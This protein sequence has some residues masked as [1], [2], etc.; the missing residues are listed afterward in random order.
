MH[1]NGLFIF[2]RDYRIVDNNGL[3]LINSKCKNVYTVFI[4]TPEQV[5]SGNHYKSN[6]AVQFMIESLGDLA[7]EIHK[8]G[9]KLHFFYGTNNKVVS[10]CIEAF[11]I[12]YVCFNA[13]YTPYALERD[14]DIVDLCKKKKIECEL[15]QD[16]YL[17]EPG[18]IFSGGGTPYKKFTPYYHAALKKHV[19]PPTKAHKIKFSQSSK[20]LSNTISL[21]TALSKFT[22]A[23]ENILVHGG[24]PDAINTLKTALKNQKH[25]AITHDEVGKPTSLLSAYIKFGCVSVREV[26]KAFKSNH[27]LIRQLI[28][29]DFYMN[30]LYAY[31]YVLGKPMKPAYSKIRWHKNARW[32]DA[33]TKGQTGF[34]IVDAGMRQMNTTGFMHNRAR[35]I[36]AS[37]LTKTL[38][39][40]WR[41]GEEYFATKLTDYDPASNNGNWQFCSSS[42][43]DSQP[44]FRIF[45]P[46]SQSIE[47]DPDCDYIKKWIPELKDVPPKHIQ[48]CNTVW[49]NYK[50]E[51]KYPKPICNYEEQKEKALAMFRAIY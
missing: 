11:D 25:Y 47:V 37:F 16:Y 27:A 23:N 19:Q 1:E 9:G 44:Y 42:G 41:E 50:K 5:G 39:I 48:K 4:F 49:K 34:P 21:V 24:R 33:W 8:Q 30:I 26:Y 40:D 2:R 32:F 7:S 45:N 6:N 15:A 35:L 43:A 22:K 46:W 3:N 10:E 29:R 18:T 14:R 13:D 17:H 36:V 28:W 51:T 20:K 12:N 38:L 31:P